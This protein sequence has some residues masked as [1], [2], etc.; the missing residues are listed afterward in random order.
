VL[1]ACAEAEREEAPAFKRPRPLCQACRARPLGAELTLRVRSL[2]SLAASGPQST[3]A[4]RSW[5]MPRGVRS[6]LVDAT[7]SEGAKLEP[8]SDEGG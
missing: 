3:T 5:R 2:R 4:Q 8:R 6:L 1:R 7:P